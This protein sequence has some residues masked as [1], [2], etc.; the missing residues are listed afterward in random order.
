MALLVQKSLIVS[1]SK[2]TKTQ[3]VFRSGVTQL[4]QYQQFYKYF[5][6]FLDDKQEGES[7]DLSE[8]QYHDFL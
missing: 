5:P 1:S 8:N 7:H 3:A 4:Y 2:V 6:P